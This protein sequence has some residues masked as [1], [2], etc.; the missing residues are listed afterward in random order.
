MGKRKKVVGRNGNRVSGMVKPKLPKVFFGVPL[1]YVDGELEPQA[2][3]CLQGAIDFGTETQ[4]YELMYRSWK[5]LSITQNSWHLMEEFLRNSDYKECT[6]YLYSGDDLTFPPD[7]IK[8]L[9]DADKPIIVGCA[10][11][12]TPPYW[13]NCDIMTGEGF[14]SKIHIT[15]KMLQDEEVVEVHA[16]GSGFMMIKREVIEAI[17]ELWK[18]YHLAFAKGMPEKFKGWEPVPFFPV[19][20]D[21]KTQLYT[22]TDYCFC[23]MARTAGFKIFLHC[24]VI[25]G[26]IWK[27]QISVLD[28]LNWRDTFG[29]SNQQQMF[30]L[31]KIE[32]VHFKVAYGAAV[33]ERPLEPEAV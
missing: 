16:A 17:D 10:T 7:A 14:A 33:E 20:F 4:S 15:R 3:I 24:G 11:W 22:S 19:L 29:C 30:P 5:G 31:Q 13:P 26:H 1:R 2:Q 12:K 6:H 23:D 8:K 18:E 21:G 9:L 32:P 28:H 27:K 25:I